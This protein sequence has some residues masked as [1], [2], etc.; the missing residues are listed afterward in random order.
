MISLKDLYSMTKYQP[1]Y[2][3][4]FTLTRNSRMSGERRQ[5]GRVITHA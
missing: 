1:L 3:T 5:H 2:T 4:K